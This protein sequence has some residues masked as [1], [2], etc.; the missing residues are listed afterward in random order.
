MSMSKKEAYEHGYDCGLNG[1][2]KTNSDYRIFSSVENTKE[3]ERGKKDGEGI[4][5]YNDIQ[6]IIDGTYKNKKTQPPER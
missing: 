5:A 6:A 3:W 1:P 2:N 4:R